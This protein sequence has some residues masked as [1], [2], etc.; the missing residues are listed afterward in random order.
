MSEYSKGTWNS[1]HAVTA[2][3]T[4][5]VT[6]TIT[7]IKSGGSWSQ[8]LPAQVESV[9]PNTATFSLDGAGTTL[10]ISNAAYTTN[11]IWGT[12]EGTYTKQ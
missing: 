6:F 8:N 9:N 7:Q 2:P 10:I 11:G 12:T 3:S 5:T 1:S 4:G